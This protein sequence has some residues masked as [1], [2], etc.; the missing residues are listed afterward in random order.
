LTKPVLHIIQ[1]QHCWLH[2]EKLIW[3]EEARSIIVS[4]LH[5]G[6][7]GHFRKSGIAV[8]QSVY[9]EDMQQLA[10]MIAH[11]QPIKI[12]AVGDLFHSHANKELDWFLRWR[13]DFAHVAFCLVKGNHDILSPDWYEKA[14]IEVINHYH[15]EGPFAFIHDTA[16]I[17][18]EQY[19][20]YYWFSGHI[21]PG[22]RMEGAAKQSL[23]LACFFFQQQHAILPAFSRFTGLQL[24]RPKKA[25]TL[26][27]IIPADHRFQTPA[28]ILRIQ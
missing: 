28:S 22:I 5:F 8:P 14:A 6:K 26:Y 27:G 9:K 7:T 21:H 13:Q 19:S 15:T 17:P 25:D 4:D 10:A 23:R 1:D 12:I 20:H 3:W 18:E 2:A 16:D 11:Y 24:I